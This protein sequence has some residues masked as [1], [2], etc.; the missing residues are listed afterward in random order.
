MLAILNYEPNHT[1]IVN[2]SDAMSEY[3]YLIDPVSS[4]RTFLQ[5]F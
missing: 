1:V 4:A 5:L 3:W 2:S